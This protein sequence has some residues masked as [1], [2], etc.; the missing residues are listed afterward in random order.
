M[1]KKVLIISFHFPPQG[2]GG[3]Q[4]TLKFSKYLPLFD[5]KPVILTASNSDSPLWDYSLL[6]ELPVETE[7]FRVPA[8][9]LSKWERKFFSLFKPGAKT[10][11]EK[12]ENALYP[13]KEAKTPK[14]NLKGFLKRIYIFFT[15]WLRI[16][17]DKIGW[18]PFAIPEGLSLIK[19]EKIDLIYTTSPPHSSQLIGLLLSKL[20]GKPW[21]ADFRDDWLEKGSALN[22]LPG[23]S[24]KLEKYLSRKVFASASFII[25]NTEFQKESY[26]RD[27]PKVKR[28]E[29][30][31][32]GF[33]AE[34]LKRAREKEERWLD[35]KLH[36]CHS[37]YFYPGTAFPLFEAL[38]YFFEE[39]PELREKIQIDLVGLLEKEYQDYIIQNQ[40]EGAIKS[41]GYVDHQSALNFILKSQVLIYLIGADKRIWREG[42]VAGKLFEYLASGKPILAFAPRDGESENIIV[43]AKSGWV[44][45]LNDAKKIK[46][47]LKEIYQLF[48]QDKLRVEQ[49]KLYIEGFERKN[50]THKLSQAFEDC[51]LQNRKT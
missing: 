43:Q 11:V 24:A 9:E 51:L 20:S 27:Y 44:T 42:E 47:K 39:N 16:P 17:D 4:R 38:K 29:A 7:V 8:F 32:N 1:R 2:G 40:L 23:L 50:L 45:D 25:A 37:G 18:A 5:W 34:D 3:V 41:W 35:E 21:V 13:D 14:T 48:L 6:K 49:N 31:Y 30:I 46:E 10:N 33:D 28:I 26:K 22:G 15:N 12:K 36:L 19:S